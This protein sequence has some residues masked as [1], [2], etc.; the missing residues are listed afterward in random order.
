MCFHICTCSDR[1]SAKQSLSLF[2]L[3]ISFSHLRLDEREAVVH[4]LVVSS[5]LTNRLPGIEKNPGPL[6]RCDMPS[7]E[8]YVCMVEGLF[9]GPAINRVVTEKNNTK[10]IAWVIRWIAS[11]IACK[12][13][14]QPRANWCWPELAFSLITRRK[15]TLILIRLCQAHH[16]PLCAWL[17]REVCERSGG[18]H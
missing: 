13:M 1:R 18:H 3:Y 9:L 15:S 4:G 8:V 2:R 6:Q 16:G 14:S 10:V 12:P 7:L 5:S 17:W 11:G